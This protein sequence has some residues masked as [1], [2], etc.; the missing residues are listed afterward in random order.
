MLKNIRIFPVLLI[1]CSL[2]VAGCGIFGSD[3]GNPLAGDLSYS[4]EGTPGTSVFLATSHS[5][6]MNFEGQ[7]IGSREIPSSGVF[8]EE[9]DGGDFDAYQISG[10]IGDPDD[11]ITLRLLSNGDV[12]D[13]TSERDEN[14]LFVVKY[15]EFPDFGFE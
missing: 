3:D 2:I 15:G 14:E 9:L 1:S 6:G 4:I 7:T 13:E 12:L 10:S 5:E 11:T 8:S